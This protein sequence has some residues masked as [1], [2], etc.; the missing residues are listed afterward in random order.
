MLFLAIDLAVVTQNLWNS[1]IETLMIMGLLFM[2]MGVACIPGV[3]LVS[4]FFLLQGFVGKVISNI[5]AKSMVTIDHRIRL[6]NEILV[7]IKLIKLYAWESCTFLFLLSTPVTILTKSPNPNIHPAFFK[8]ISEGRD[9]ELK[10]LRKIANWKLINTVCGISVPIIAGGLSFVTYSALGNTFQPTMAFATLSLFNMLRISMSFF[11]A[12]V[13]GM[14]TFFVSLQ[15]LQ[16]II[17]MPELEAMVQ[18]DTDFQ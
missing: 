17:D 10:T 5:K 1:V 14:A 6:M 7:A 15:R 2:Y 13:K 9:K 16:D 12:G 8:S 11:P 18:A 3:V 4:S